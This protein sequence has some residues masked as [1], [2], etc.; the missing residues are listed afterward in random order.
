MKPST[1]LEKFHGTINCLQCR[2]SAQL[3][4]ECCCQLELQRGLRVN[5]GCA[6]GMSILRLS[7]CLR[8]ACRLNTVRLYRDPAS[9]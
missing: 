3:Q 6:S 7:R 5:D 9:I 4:V 1:S 8:R 2:C